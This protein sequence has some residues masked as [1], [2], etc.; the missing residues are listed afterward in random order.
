MAPEPRSSETARQGRE[1]RSTGSTKQVRFPTRRRRVRGQSNGIQKREV[2]SLKRESSSL[3]QQTLT[4]MSFVSSF[5]E[6]A[7]LM[8]DN[9]S[10]EDGTAYDKSG[11][12]VPQRESKSRLTTEPQELTT[13]EDTVIIQDSCGSTY[14]SSGDDDDDASAG[15]NIS[16]P[17]WPEDV[18][19]AAT[20]PPRSV[21]WADSLNIVR[22]SPRRRAHLRRNL[23]ELR[24]TQSS[25]EEGTALSAH[26]H[27][28]ATEADDREIPDSDEDD[29][30]LQLRDFNRLIH[31]ET[32]YAGH[33]TQL[34]LEEL[35]SLE[36][37]ELTP[38]NSSARRQLMASQNSL[39]FTPSNGTTN[40]K[41]DFSMEDTQTQHT[42]IPQTPAF[43]LPSS[44]SSPKTQVGSDDQ[45]NPSQGQKFHTPAHTELPS[46]GQIFESQRVP[47]HIL[48]SL[49][50]VSARTD[51]LLPTPSEVL[52]LI[53]SGSESFLHLAY[54]VPEQVQRFW[55]FSLGILRY[56]ACIQPGR[57][58][59]HG[60]DYRIDQV[61]QLNN[62]LEERDMQEEG[63]VNGT[64]Q[65][66]I[67]L[68][69]A[70]AGQLLW[71]LRC[72]TFDDGELQR[73][74]GDD[75]RDDI[76]QVSDYR[77]SSR[78]DT[79][80]SAATLQSAETDTYIN[81]HDA[82]QP[83]SLIFQD[84]GSS[85]ATLPASAVLG[86]SPLLTKSQMLSDSLIS[87]KL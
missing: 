74:S 73:A 24:S 52:D 27:F 2:S 21:S 64:V 33:E 66:Y 47:L 11:L 7:T 82:G 39:A 81:D 1:Y 86:S 43:S 65:R 4:Q 40:N 71:N 35:A 57:P 12:T 29:E 77:S 18:R 44:P 51:I 63:W 32:L 58:R 15:V 45:T 62:A 46:Q 10:D 72:A 54:R 69:P 34:I 5:G 75:G 59:G 42:A 13:R 84:H 83:S 49:A 61:Y 36:H 28:A 31:Q 14:D 76:S 3:K 20:A 30:E 48:Q 26:V 50:P 16:P 22:D 9:A 38:G 6:D 68:P 80:S 17:R 78:K 25:Q 56:M 85:A 19:E 37:P 23:E 67:Y 8:D 53:I 87:D 41:N 55:L 70:I 79:R 60:W